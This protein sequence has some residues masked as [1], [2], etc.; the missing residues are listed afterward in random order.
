L[1]GIG[2]WHRFIDGKQ[3]FDRP[4]D[5][6]RLHSTH[7]HAK[8]TRYR[9]LA[10]AYFAASTDRFSRHVV[11]GFEQGVKAIGPSR[12]GVG[13]AGKARPSNSD[14]DL[15]AIRPGLTGARTRESAS[16]WPPGAK[17]IETLWPSRASWP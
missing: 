8:S 16:V 17:T 3:Q 7:L 12:S 4:Y 15:I 5:W 9:T 10:F 2:T 11:V 13:M 14:Q 1:S 6:H